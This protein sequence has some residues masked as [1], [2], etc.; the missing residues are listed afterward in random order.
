MSVPPAW[1]VS[2]SSFSSAFKLMM[3]PL[4]IYLLHVLKVNKVEAVSI[5]LDYFAVKALN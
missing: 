5:S 3:G 1:E 2:R 4:I